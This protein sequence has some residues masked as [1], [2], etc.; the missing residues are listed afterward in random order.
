MSRVRHA[1]SIA[2]HWI[3]SAHESRLDTTI[4]FSMIV[5][6]LLSTFVA[7]FVHLNL[8]G[9][10]IVCLF[11]ILV[12]F[13]VNRRPGPRATLVLKG[14]SI[15][16]S[17]RYL[18][19]RLTETLNF[20]TWTQSILGTTLVA[21]EI[22]AF[23]M[24]ILSYF[25]SLHPL[26]RRVAP[27]PDDIAS[28]PS[29]DI[30]IPTYNEEL[31]IVRQTVLAAMGIDWPADRLHVYILDD[32]HR[33]EFQE[34]AE[35]CGAGYIARSE[36]SHA[37]AGNLN[38]AMTITK[39][40][41]IAIFDCDHI[42]KRS[43][44]QETV[45]PFMSEEK[46]A[47]LQTPH[48]F[49]SADPFQRNFSHGAIVPP[50]ENLFYGLIQDGNDFWNA[51]FF[52]GSCAV[53]RRSA[54]M[55]IGGVAVETVTEDMH[56]A[57]K[58][59]RLGWST[60]YIGKP[61][62]AGLATERLIL[63]VGQ[64]MRWA[65][66]MLQIFRLDNPLFGPGL[67]FAQRLCYFSAIASFLFAIPRLIFLSAP[68]AYL[69][70]N[71]TLIDASPFAI[72]IYAIPH[73]MHSVLTSARTNRNWRY[74]LWSE[75]YET[76]LAPFL[77]RVTIMTLL[78]PRRGKFNVTEKG[79]ILDRSYLDWSAIYP[80][81]YIAIALILG[82]VFGLYRLFFQHNDYIVSNALMMNVVWV[83][84]SITILLA[85]ISIGRESMQ[86][87]KSPRVEMVVPVMVRVEDGRLFHFMTQ[88]MSYGGCQLHGT[89][90]AE[91][92]VKDSSVTAMIRDHNDTY[93]LPAIVV[94]AAQSGELALRWAETTLL[95][96]AQI[97]RVIFGRLDAWRS[98]ADYKPDSLP[99]SI[100]LIL[101][102]IF[103]LFKP[104]TFRKQKPSISLMPRVT[105]ATPQK[106]AV[107]VRPNPGMIRSLA[108]VLG[109]GAIMLTGSASAQVNPADLPLP[110]GMVSSG[111]Q[112]SP[113]TQPSPPA[114]MPATTNP[115]VVGNSTTNT[116]LATPG[117]SASVTVPDPHLAPVPPAL[118][119]PGSAILDQGPAQTGP[120]LSR[121]ELENARTTSWSFSQL[122]SADTLLMTPWIPIQGLNF[123]VSSSEV[124][125]SATLSLFGS[126]SPE[127]LPAGSGVTIFL[128]DQYI[129][130][131]HPDKNRPQFGPL[132]F[133][134]NP[135]YFK[136]HNVLTFHFAGQYTLSCGDQTSPV[137]W[138]KIL[139]QSTLSITTAPMPPSR[140]LAALPEPFFDEAVLTPARVPFVIARQSNSHTL[141]ASAILASWFGSMAQY[142]GVSFP[143]MSQMPPSGNAVVI[144]PASTLSE[145]LKGQA[146]IDGPTVLETV[147]ANDP[148][149]AL[150][151]VTG[152]TDSEVLAAARSVAF[153][154][155]GFP[156]AA[157]ILA[158]EVTIQPRQPY[159]APGF[160]TRSQPVRVG[161]LVALSSLQGYGYVPGTISVPF[162]TSPDIYTWRDHPLSLHF[163]VRGPLGTEIDRR[164]SHVDV[165]V[166]G[167]YLK[168]VSLAPPSDLP[169]WIKRFWPAA[170]RVQSASVAI[171]PWA[172][173]GANTLD[174]YLESRPVGR[175][176]CS[177]MTQDL[178]MS[179][180]PDSTIDLT[181]AYHYTQLP[182]LAYFANSGFPFTR[183]ADLSDTAVVLPSSH[184]EG[185]ESVYLDL[186]GMIGAFTQYPVSGLTVLH[187]DAVSETETR[188][189]IVLDTVASSP[190]IERFLRGTPYSLNGTTLNYSSSTF[191]EPFH[192]LSRSF[193]SQSTGKTPDMLRA[194]SATTSLGDGGVL[195]ERRS[196]FSSNA[197]MV[198]MLSE[199]PQ[200]LERL[201]QAVHD[202]KV[203]P[204][205]QG[206][207]AIVNGS[208]VLSTR[209]LPT[210]TI[211]SLPFWFW[212]DL[213]LGNHP[214]R[215]I[216]LAMFGIGVGVLILFRI[217]TSHARRRQQELR[218]DK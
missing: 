24:L 85:A 8:A 84:I 20:S 143:V 43:F 106:T 119:A 35:A 2:E 88:N 176:D 19:W 151:I 91:A 138:A 120:A 201:L 217:L 123:G 186:M 15:I 111:N 72:A 46:L 103:E 98:W 144:G 9:Q 102:S 39:G 204:M 134:V 114:A 167:L 28:W 45:A 193:S 60:A 27:M 115:T 34:F 139:G 62:A 54:L 108:L 162:R 58:L 189:L 127:M 121:D 210:Y 105:P 6:A 169:D 116:P 178:R 118:A 122:G 57:L 94:R 51:T 206:D 41:L 107:I 42:A 59:Q 18:S 117:I 71:Q 100:G 164:R 33:E 215:V 172:I 184:T 61:M 177:G 207:L 4:K 180:D 205:I 40:E 87:R 200:G 69:L 36:H 158:P 202:T 86:I 68:M 175:R 195:I 188:N 17:L 110:G 126:L 198:L 173:Y 209:N 93:C 90:P 47:L 5:V 14:F 185:V 25:Q 192:V 218:R 135:L 150:L 37:K 89:A 166:N 149:G 80:N 168:S 70:F 197:T 163:T 156:H 7:A 174:F 182:N 64:R 11:G 148:F 145:F 140:D 29:V 187:S 153:G 77:A 48:H 52:C 67:N 30:Y 83:S 32:G 157:R 208:H 55:E 13:V 154:S 44:L 183:M 23:V 147:N 165:S 38:H 132:S 191:L 196:P 216:I 129:G 31:R 104:A 81:V 109:L 10:T 22:Y 50:E 141:E 131:V 137:L 97:V 171:P 21:A 212:P 66:G 101:R 63:H 214:F 190:A 78:F 170:S 128:N 79:G 92:F 194:L 99:R 160:V 155:K 213:Y 75:V 203:Q 74:S 179:I 159:D 95:Q 16:V 76:T 136:E 113:A 49:Y 161:D 96:E 181:R 125:T 199:N 65:R 130:V 12:F 112:I 3:D 146:S 142:R 211:G 152:R 1:I 82:L 26:G 124:V 56:T 53:I 73:L 133:Q